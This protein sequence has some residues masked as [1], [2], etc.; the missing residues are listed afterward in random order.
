MHLQSASSGFPSTRVLSA[1]YPEIREELSYP[2]QFFCD[3]VR[4]SIVLG[5]NRIDTWCR[6]QKAL[7]LQLMIPGLTR[8]DFSARQSMS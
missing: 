7:Q 1:N 4:S 2:T 5:N 8:I 3:S 6:D